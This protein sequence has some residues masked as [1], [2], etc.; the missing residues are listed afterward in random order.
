MAD[1][2]TDPEELGRRWLKNICPERGASV[3]FPSGLE[4]RSVIGFD[5]FLAAWHQDR[6]PGSISGN[7]VHALKSF[8]LNWRLD[9]QGGYKVPLRVRN[10]E[11]GEEDEIVCTTD[12]MPDFT[13]NKRGVR[14]IEDLFMTYQEWMDA[15]ADLKLNLSGPS[16]GAGFEQYEMAMMGGIVD[17]SSDVVLPSMDGLEDIEKA[18]E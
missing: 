12:R 7:L 16:A 2:I 11:T 8:V 5:Q 17:A 9:G 10:K 18:L 3:A 14:N 13:Y 1:L 4:L 6:K 15:V